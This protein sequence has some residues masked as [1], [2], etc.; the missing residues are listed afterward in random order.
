MVDAWF[1]AGAIAL[2]LVLLLVKAARCAHSGRS[3]P[4]AS[5]PHPQP[6]HTPRRSRRGGS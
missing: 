4:F 5:S 6:R 1:L 3:A 2:G